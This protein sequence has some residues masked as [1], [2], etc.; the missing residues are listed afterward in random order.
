[1]TLLPCSGCDIDL[2]EVD[3]EETKTMVETTSG[4]VLA[5]RPG[6]AEVPALVCPECGEVTAL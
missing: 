4:P 2:Y 6:E 1:M 3:A 5:G